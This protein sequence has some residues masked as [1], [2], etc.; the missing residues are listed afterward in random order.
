MKA[1]FVRK[2]YCYPWPRFVWILNYFRSS[3]ENWKSGNESSVLVSERKKYICFIWNSLLKMCFLRNWYWSS[4]LTALHVACLILLQRH[5]VC[6]RILK[7]IFIPVSTASV[8]IPWRFLDVVLF[9]EISYSNF[10]FK[11]SLHTQHIQLSI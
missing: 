6:Q 2:V 9:L 11:R 7:E 1:H 5:S 4:S 3:K 10:V 8:D